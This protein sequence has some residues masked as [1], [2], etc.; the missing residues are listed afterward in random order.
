MISSLSFGDSLLSCRSIERRFVL[1]TDRISGNFILEN[2]WFREEN[3]FDSD[4]SFDFSSVK[5]LLVKDVGDINLLT[6]P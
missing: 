4:F 3:L 2:E 6:F 1:D 5:E